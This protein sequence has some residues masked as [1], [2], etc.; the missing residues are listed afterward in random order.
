MRCR[1]NLL[2]AQGM[3]ARFVENT[4]DVMALVDHHCRNKAVAGEQA[5]LS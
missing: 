2:D 5:K 4:V 3:F 1:G